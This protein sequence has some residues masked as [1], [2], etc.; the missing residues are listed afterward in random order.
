MTEREVK[1]PEFHMRIPA[2]FTRRQDPICGRTPLNQSKTS[3]KHE[4]E[5][6]VHC[7]SANLTDYMP[8]ACPAAAERRMSCFSM[9]TIQNVPGEIEDAFA[10]IQGGGQ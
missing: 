3:P 10:R 6:P 9:R 1:V 2:C 7:E 5:A 4:N 8:G